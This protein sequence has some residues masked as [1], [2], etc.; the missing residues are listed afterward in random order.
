LAEVEDTVKTMT[1]SRHP[2]EYFLR[3]DGCYIML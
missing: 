1:L 2:L 3:I